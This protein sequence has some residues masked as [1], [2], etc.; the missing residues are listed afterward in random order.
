MNLSC[1]VISPFGQPFDEYYEKIY[2]PAI[3]KAGLQPIRGDEVYNTGAVID[4]IFAAISSSTLVVCDATGR[5]PNVNYELGVA[6]A[7][8]KPAILITQSV[9]D[10]PFD[11]RHLR[12]ITYDRTKVDWAKQLEI[13]IHKTIL[14]VLGDPERALAWKPKGDALVKL[15]LN[16]SVEE[17]FISYTP[18]PSIATLRCR[19][20]FVLLGTR[21]GDVHPGFRQFFEDIYADLQSLEIQ[22]TNTEFIQ[23]RRI[24]HD[25]KH[26][27]IHISL[28]IIHQKGEK[29]TFTALE[30][31]NTLHD[32]H[33]WYAGQATYVNVSVLERNIWSDSFFP[34]APE[35]YSERKE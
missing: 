23:L 26:G 17:I 33:G 7:L 4:D 13:S 31:Q 16:D 35:F 8:Q 10:V 22:I 15:G 34:N 20:Q 14:A 28:D 19:N 32:G 24:W 5:N 18:N 12:V 30:I 2:Q 29:P 21:S 3:A 27:S 6:H 11:Y 9:D 1:F 25:D